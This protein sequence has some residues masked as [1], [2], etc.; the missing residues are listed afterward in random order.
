MPL[1]CFMVPIAA[2]SHGS[3]AARQIGQWC[4]IFGVTWQGVSMRWMQINV[5]LRLILPT[6]QPNELP[7]QRSR[8]INPEGLNLIGRCVLRPL[9]WKGH[10]WYI[11]LRYYTIG[12]IAFDYLI[13]KCI[14][15]SV[16]KVI[17][18]NPQMN[19]NIVVMFLVRSNSRPTVSAVHVVPL[20]MKGCICHF[21]KWLIHPFISKGTM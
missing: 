17:C 15:T 7:H 19:M 11:G 20:D 8:I 10:P 18:R 3:T 1:H 5:I 16:V 13:R 21:A 14:W 6:H 12:R 9:I 4:R 2:Q